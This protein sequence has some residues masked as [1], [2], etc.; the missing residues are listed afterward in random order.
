MRAAAVCGLA[1][2]P[3]VMGRVY[4]ADREQTQTDGT[5]RIKAA[6]LPLYEQ[7]SKEN[8]EFVAE[9]TTPFLEQVSV[10]RQAI[11]AYLDTIQ[12]TT[13]KVKE[14]WNTGKKYSDD[15]QTYIKE[16]PGA[17]PRAG[18]VTIAGLGG[19]VAGYKGGAFRKA[20]F[21]MGAMTAA[22]S[23]CFPHQAIDVAGQGWTA[24]SQQA[25][26]LWQQTKSPDKATEEKKSKVPEVKPK[27]G[28]PATAEA[29]KAAAP[30]SGST[31]N[32]AGKDSKK[33]VLDKTASAKS[34]KAQKDF[35]QSKKEDQDLYT[36]RTG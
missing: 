11:W 33:P 16:D 10:V 17:V 13:N 23:L 9:G 25:T 2:A 12:G 7:P 26:G 18:L 29:E 31:S 32:K 35:G 21:S 36:T 24:V 6:D 8:F 27:E 1:G 14:K 34:V 30:E 22:A 19:I 3:L 4:A 28:K 5:K 20:F 15:F